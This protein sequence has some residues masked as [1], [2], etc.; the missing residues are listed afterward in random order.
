MIY[1]FSIETPYDIQHF[2]YEDDDNYCNIDVIKQ[3][4]NVFYYTLFY[5]NNIG[6]LIGFDN[7]NYELPEN[8]IIFDSE[9]LTKLL[10]GN[11]YD[12]LDLE[13]KEFHDF[14]LEQKN[15]YIFRNL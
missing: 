2:Y 9:K 8:L 14:L 12:V 10:F 6:R 3:G 7:I 4:G 13:C 15:K 11:D 1:L 5:I